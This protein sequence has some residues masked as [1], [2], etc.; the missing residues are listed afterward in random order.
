M[1]EARR[2]RITQ[3]RKV[4]PLPVTSS[5]GSAKVRERP[6]VCVRVRARAREKEISRKRDNTANDSEEVRI[7]VP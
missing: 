5:I 6:R 3:I 2:A 1:T 7:N 4:R